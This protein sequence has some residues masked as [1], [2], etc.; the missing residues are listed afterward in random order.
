[1]DL[2]INYCARRQ[3]ME[4]QAVIIMYDVTRQHSLRNARRWFEICGSLFSPNI[5][6]ALAGNKE[7]LVSNREVTYEV[8]RVSLGL[9]KA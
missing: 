1:M 9:R 3:I 8:I 7:D 6:I 5:F 2:P 4:K